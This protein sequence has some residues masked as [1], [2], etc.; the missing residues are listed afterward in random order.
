MNN[1]TPTAAGR[2]AAVCPSERAFGL[3]VRRIPRVALSR[4][5][6]KTC[7]GGSGKNWWPLITVGSSTEKTRWWPKASSWLPNWRRSTESSSSWACG[8]QCFTEKRAVSVRRGGFQRTLRSLENAAACDESHGAAILTSFHSASRDGQSPAI[9]PGML[10]LPPVTAHS[11]PASCRV[12][13]R[14][15]APCL[16]G[17][18]RSPCRRRHH[19]FHA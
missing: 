3:P 10:E 9:T 5:G 16:G 15:A 14:V 4:T 13:W 7:S 17:D 8:T 1:V 18:A 6:V 19:F 12:S 11:P 2:Q